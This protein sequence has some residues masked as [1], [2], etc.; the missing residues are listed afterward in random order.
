[1]K[2]NFPL[3]FL[4]I[5]GVVALLGIAALVLMLIVKLVVT[6]VVVLAAGTLVFKI[7]SNR[8]RRLWG[9]DYRQMSPLQRQSIC[10]KIEP[11]FDHDAQKSKTI[12]PVL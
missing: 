11:I 4:R 7:A 10:N 2:K 6:A 12:I 5:G 1:M 9:N 8:R 3:L